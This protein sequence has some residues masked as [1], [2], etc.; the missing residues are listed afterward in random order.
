MIVYMTKQKATKTSKTDKLKYKTNFG[1]KLNSL[2]SSLRCPEVG[3]KC[4]HLIY[5]LVPHFPN[6]TKLWHQIQTVSMI[7]IRGGIDGK[8]QLVGNPQVKNTP[9][10]VSWGTVVNYEINYKYLKHMFLL[11]ISN[12][13]SIICYTNN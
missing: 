7:Y 11:Q 2:S 5:W 12:Q 10:Q 4:I 1:L 6:P 3:Q 8:I 13:D 9:A